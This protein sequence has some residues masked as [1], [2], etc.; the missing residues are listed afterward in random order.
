MDV[1]EIAATTEPTYL[2]HKV[3]TNQI[4]TGMSDT[5]P[6]F[7]DV[8]KEFACFVRTFRGGTIVR[9]LIPDAP[10]MDPNADYYFSVDDIIA[11]LKCLHADVG[12]QLNERFLSACRRLGYSAEQALR[13]AFREVPL[14]RD[15]AQAVIGKSLNHVRKAIRK[16]SRQISATKKQLGRA[17]PLGLVIIANERNIDLTPVQLLHFMSMELRAMSDGHIDGL[18]YLTPNLYHPIGQDGVMRSLWLPGY[19]RAGTR[20]TDFVDELGV[21]WCR[22]RE[23]LDSN[24]VSS[25][26]THEPP[27]SNFHVRPALAVTKST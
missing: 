8:E 17:D 24:L 23:R 20:L 22:F 18:I 25:E 1:A 9:D 16:A 5:D 19:R 10:S 7:I 3:S 11:E 2:Y 6:K 15:V 14:P 26:R 21:A 27:L 12:E 4:G 13:I